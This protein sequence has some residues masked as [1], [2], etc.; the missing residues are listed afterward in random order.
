MNP[1]SGL[2]GLGAPG[3]GLLANLEVLLQNR[4][5][6]ENPGY[7]RNPEGLPYV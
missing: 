5:R 4:W 7:T 1:T 6:A 3:T 2:I